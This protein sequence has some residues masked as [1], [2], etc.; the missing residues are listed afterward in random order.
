L[1]RIGSTVAVI[2]V[3]LAW[4]TYN[5]AA[6]NL[7]Q[8]AIRT[9][10]VQAQAPANQIDG[11]LKPAAKMPERVSR[12]VTGMPSLTKRRLFAGIG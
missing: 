1:R 7:Q 9:G 12:L 10:H 2:F 11:G 3:A 8:Q 4:L 5:Q 6:T